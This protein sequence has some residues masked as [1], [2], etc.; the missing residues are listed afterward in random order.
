VLVVA[1]HYGNEDI[2][3]AAL[4]ALPLLAVLAG[5]VQWHRTRVR[6]LL[7]ALVIPAL[8][9]CFVIGDMGFDYIYVVRP[10]DLSSV[11]F[12]ENTAPSGA[13]LIS[14]SDQA[15]SAVES[16]D[17]YQRFVF[18]YLNLPKLLKDE[19]FNAARAVDNLSRS[20][21]DDVI[22][23]YE[24]TGQVPSYYVATTQQA[25]AEWAEGGVVS[26]D[27][28]RSFSTALDRS[29]SWEKVD[30]T[31]SAT[32]YRFVTKDVNFKNLPRQR[33]SVR[34]VSLST[35]CSTRVFNTPPSLRCAV[36]RHQRST[37]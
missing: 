27:D 8:V 7:I 36:A 31:G 25:A 18:D 35:G 15:Y 11:Q 9:L 21:L 10:T 2:F 16:T 3:R 26:L 13:T 12:F 30:Q 17:R 33:P 5:R 1:V 22:G 14:V 32:V 28:Y 29:S 6:T 4:F 34:T 24:R 37:G 20:T 19:K 23:T